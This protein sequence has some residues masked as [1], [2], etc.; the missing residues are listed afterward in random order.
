MLI[1]DRHVDPTAMYPRQL[2]TLGLAPAI[3]LTNGVIGLI[4]AENARKILAASLYCRALAGAVSIK[5]VVA[6]QTG[7]LK[8]TTLAIDAVPEKFK[9]MTD[10]AVFLVS[11]AVKTKAPATAIAFSAADTINNGAAAGL[12]WGA[13]RVQVNAAGTVSTVSV[14]A[15]QAYATEAAAIA[16]LPA[17]D[18]DKVSLGYITVKTKTS[19][20][21]WTATIDD[22]TAGSDCTAANFYSDTA[23]ECLTGA[24][25]AVAATDVDG[26]VGATLANVIAEDD[27]M[28]A[29]LATTDGTGQLTDG[30]LNLWTRAAR[31]FRGE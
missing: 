12:Y 19:A 18:A 2:H 8:G 14:S 25:A 21:K 17:A 28:I 7:L 22:L 20:V 10:T 5:L 1:R 26:T 15:D 29:I 6:P 4:K 11:K 9:T 23:R 30:R 31:V 3:S 24:I 16:A 27:E 13:W